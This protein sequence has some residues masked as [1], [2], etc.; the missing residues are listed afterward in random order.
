MRLATIVLLLVLSLPALGYTLSYGGFAFE[1]SAY[2]NDVVAFQPDAKDAPCKDH[3][4]FVAIIERSHYEVQVLFYHMQAFIRMVEEKPRIAAHLT[5]ELR[6]DILAF[7]KFLKA[8]YSLP[9]LQQKFVSFRDL[10]K[11]ARTQESEPHP[12]LRATNPS[13][14]WLLPYITKQDYTI[15][16]YQDYLEMAE[17]RW[18]SRLAYEEFAGINS[19]ELAIQLALQFMDY[20]ESLGSLFKGK[21]GQ[22]FFLGASDRHH[23][24]HLHEL[25]AQKL[26]QVGRASKQERHK[27]HDE[28]AGF[29]EQRQQSGEKLAKLQEEHQEKMVKVAQ[30]LS[31]KHYSFSEHQKLF[32][33]TADDSAR[34]RI[35]PEKLHLGIDRYKRLLKKTSKF[36]RHNFTEN[37]VDKYEDGKFN[38]TLAELEPMSKKRYLAYRLSQGID[39]LLTIIATT[40]GIVLVPFTAG[41]SSIAGN[42]VVTGINSIFS[43]VTSR[44]KNEKWGPTFERAFLR[45]GV[46]YGSNMIPIIG[47]LNNYVTGLEE[48]RTATSLDQDFENLFRHDKKIKTVRPESLGRP[49]VLR[50]LRERVSYLQNALVPLLWHLYPHVKLD[51]KQRHYT[52]AV[53]GKLVALQGELEER[54]LKATLRYEYL[55]AAGKVE[56]HQL[57]NLAYHLGN[58]KSGAFITPRMVFY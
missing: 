43:V 7:C 3:V 30:K 39:G 58:E 2:Q 33:P 38:L 13:H 54:L 21:V 57:F 45:T 35:L 8:H 46:S 55:L 48:L 36:Y 56:D 6:L 50:L 9:Q 11:F 37:I 1:Q 25:A 28:L 16:S 15:A 24:K 18:K 10:Q 5:G 32:M 47:D 34:A 42:Y 29:E 17:S 51:D 12:L 53:I 14:Y 31:I 40:I 44:C 27:H 19:L 20:Q 22:G 26:D 52:L 49:L 4:T 23:A 41:L